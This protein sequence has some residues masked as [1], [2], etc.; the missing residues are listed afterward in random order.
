[1]IVGVWSRKSIFKTLWTVLKMLWLRIRYHIITKNEEWIGHAELNSYMK[2]SI[3]SI[4]QRKQILN[5]GN[6]TLGFLFGNVVVGPN[7]GNVGQI[8]NETKNPVFDPK[9]PE[10]L[11]VALNRAIQLHNQGKG[12]QNRDYALNNWSTDKISEKYYRC[13]KKALNSSSV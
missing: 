11:K 2:S 6:M 3:I 8:L 10:S 12:E 9:S 13:Y 1:M 5:S 7:I 4:I